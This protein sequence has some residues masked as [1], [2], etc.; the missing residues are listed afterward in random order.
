M[1][2]EQ[3]MMMTD[4]VVMMDVGDEDVDGDA[5]G[6]G[7]DAEYVDDGGDGEERW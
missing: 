1:Q 4:V 2:T 7:D 6:D 3:I 5:D